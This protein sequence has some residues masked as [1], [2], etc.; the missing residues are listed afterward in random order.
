MMGG[1]S[2][3]NLVSACAQISLYIVSC[4]SFKLFR[5]SLAGNIVQSVGVTCMRF[6]LTMVL[7]SSWACPVYAGYVLFKEK[8]GSPEALRQL[9]HAPC[10]VIPPTLLNIPRKPP[11]EG[12]LVWLA[13]TS[14]LRPLLWPVLRWRI[15]SSIPFHF[16]STFFPP[17]H[18]IP[19]VRNEP[20]SRES[21]YPLPCT[22]P[23]RF[24]P[25]L[26]IALSAEISDAQW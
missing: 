12:S 11:F 13:R 19:S 1:A 8:P 9:N 18:W 25:A 22:L 7:L 4:R 24:R 15:F 21:E 14:Q 16:S 20:E 10:L 2:Y 17:A 6:C 23:V 26:S 5:S 3:S